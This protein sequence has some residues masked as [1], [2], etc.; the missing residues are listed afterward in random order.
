MSYAFDEEPES[1]IIGIYN[2]AG[3]LVATAA[4]ETGLGKHT[5]TWDGLDSDGNAVPAG[6]YTF[7]VSAQNADGDQMDVATAVFG[8]VTGVETG[9]EGALL[10]IGS[11][12]VPLSEIISVKQPTPS[13]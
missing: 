10:A 3:N 5:F 6:N 11:I 7:N 4:A 13:T 9:A 8:T 12:N 2:E 1:A